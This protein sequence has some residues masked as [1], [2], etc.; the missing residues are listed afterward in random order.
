MAKYALLSLAIA[1]GTMVAATKLMAGDE[2]AMR[3]TKQWR[4]MGSIVTIF[5]E[6]QRPG[7]FALSEMPDRPPLMLNQL[8]L[9]SGG[10]KE[11]QNVSI[12]LLRKMEEGLKSVE[13]EGASVMKDG[14]IPLEAGDVIRVQPKKK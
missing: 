11:G 8:I 5:G 3:D 6:V 4:D 2:P 1:I 9:S 7:F 10:L 13:I 12:T 14:N